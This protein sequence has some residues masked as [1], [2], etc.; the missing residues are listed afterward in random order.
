MAFYDRI[1][2][3]Y[4]RVP[5]NVFYVLGAVGQKKWLFRIIFDRQQGKHYWRGE[6]LTQLSLQG[7]ILR[8][9]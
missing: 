9:E 1:W 2:I 8:I 6:Q 5:Y 3:L 7:T 4:R